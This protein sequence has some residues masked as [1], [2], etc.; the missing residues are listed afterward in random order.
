VRNC[1]LLILLAAREDFEYRVE[2]ET[3]DGRRLQWPATAPQ[4]NQTVVVEES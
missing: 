1:A 4:M 3:A 2:A